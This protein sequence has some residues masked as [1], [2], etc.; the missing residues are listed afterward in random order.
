M[1][2]ES[3]PSPDII[4]VE[5]SGF[6]CGDSFAARGDDD[7]FTEVVY[8]D[9]HGVTIVGFGKVG[10]EVHSDGFPYSGRDRVRM[11]GNLSS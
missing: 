6:F 3:S 11:Q 5:L 7:S 8:Y 2:W 9:K 10:D 1:L 4:Q